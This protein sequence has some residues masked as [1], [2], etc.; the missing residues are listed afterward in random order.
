MWLPPPL[1]AIAIRIIEPLD[2]FLSSIAIRIMEP[3]DY[4]WSSIAIQIIEPLD[5]ISSSIAIKIIEPLDS[6]SSSIAIRI[7]EPLDFLFVH[8]MFKKSHIKFYFSFQCLTAQEILRTYHIL[9][10]QGITKDDFVNMCPA[11]VYQIDEHACGDSAIPV[12]CA[13]LQ[14]SELMSCLAKY[15]NVRHPQ[16]AGWSIYQIKPKG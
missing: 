6:I 7:F 13:G 10:K 5:C 1:C 12:Q 4:I 14:S 8:Y 9:M 11:I 3:L 15:G 16:N 2:S